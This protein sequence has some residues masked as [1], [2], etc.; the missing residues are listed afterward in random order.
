MLY[1]KLLRYCLVFTLSIRSALLSCSSMPKVAISPRYSL[2]RSF[3]YDF[4]Q[5]ISS[6]Y[7]YYL[8]VLRKS[9]FL[10]NFGYLL[11]MS[12]SHWNIILVIHSSSKYINNIRKHKYIASFS[13][14]SFFLSLLLLF[15]HVRKIIVHQPNSSIVHQSITNTVIHI[16]N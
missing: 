5:N 2:F 7:R 4:V 11:V 10:F 8:L 15:N 3:C 16:Q 12:Y 13:H 1:L 9:N 6:I 14:H